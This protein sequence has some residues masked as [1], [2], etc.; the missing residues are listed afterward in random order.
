MN[1]Y[2]LASGSKGNMTLIESQKVLLS[3]DI[4]IS[5]NKLQ[6]KLN[7]L[8][9]TIQKIQYLLITHE[10]L[11]H[12]AGL[13]KLFE[14]HQPHTYM[15][16]GTYD[17]LS[18]DIKIM[19]QPTLHIIQSEKTF[20]IE[21]LK[22][23]PFLL[24]HDAKEPVGF[25][26]EDLHYKVVHAADTGYIDQMYFQL[27]QHAHLYVIES[28]HHPEK[29]LQSPRPMHLKKRI[30]GEKGHLSNEDAA[31]LIN[32]WMGPFKT[33][34]LITHISEDCNAPLDIEKA[35]VKYIKRPLDLEIIYAQQHEVV[36]VKL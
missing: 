5:K 36:M 25:V 28:N 4:G 10:H 9:F 33:Y 19:I 14:I 26:I 21:H 2:S 24:S 30:L 29:L 22:I 7:T 17:S 6:E 13:K 15:T 3:V 32:G 23:T 18:Q 8:A 27:L 1:I 35:I 20:L 11:D 16:Q 12:T 31:Q 34:W